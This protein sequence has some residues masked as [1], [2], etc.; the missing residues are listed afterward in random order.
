MATLGEP[1]DAA[2]AQTHP[3]PYYHVE[4]CAPRSRPRD[5]MVKPMRRYF[6]RRSM[7]GDVVYIRGIS[8]KHMSLY[9]HPSL[10]TS[11]FN[12]RSRESVTTAT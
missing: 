3:A 5:F 12:H 6:V 2:L 9:S 11:A 1:P 7:G 10:D 8:C 4:D